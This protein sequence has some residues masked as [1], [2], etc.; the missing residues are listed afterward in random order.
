MLHHAD[1]NAHHAM[2]E[3]TPQAWQQPA[4]RRAQVRKPSIIARM[5][6]ALFRKV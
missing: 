2:G 3:R 1:F 4:P 6:R 5:L